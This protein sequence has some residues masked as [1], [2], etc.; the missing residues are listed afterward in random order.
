MELKKHSAQDGPH[1]YMAKYEALKRDM[2]IAKRAEILRLI[3]LVKA[4]KEDLISLT[5]DELIRLYG[6]EIE[7]RFCETLS[8]PEI[9]WGR[10]CDPSEQPDTEEPYPCYWELSSK[11]SNKGPEQ[12]N[13][14]N[15]EEV[16][17][18]VAGFALLV[19]VIVKIITGIIEF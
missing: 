5:D 14:I 19:Y 4:N 9:E 1:K 7:N 13:I 16:L 17:G 11:L 10:L 15:W 8:P 12:Q 6:Q 18:A 2:A 3:R